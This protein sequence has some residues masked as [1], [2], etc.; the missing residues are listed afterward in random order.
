MSSSF[1]P[2]VGSVADVAAMLVPLA[3]LA[4]P[5]EVAV[6]A[7]D[8][9]SRLLTVGSV[10]APPGR[11]NADHDCLAAE[12]PPGSARVWVVGL[13]PPAPQPQWVRRRWVEVLRRRLAWQGVTLEG[14]VDL[15]ERSRGIR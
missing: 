1:G 15:S 12:I 8:T 13:G 5:T 2:V 14:W 9:H 4:E 11:P 7:L 6:V 3:E 10:L